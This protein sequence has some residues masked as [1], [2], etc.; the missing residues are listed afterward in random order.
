MRSGGNS[1]GRPGRASAPSAPGRAGFGPD[2]LLDRHASRRGGA[3]APREIGV[4]GRA[5]GSQSPARPQSPLSAPDACER[6]VPRPR[7]RIAGRSRSRARRSEAASEDGLKVPAARLRKFSKWR[8][9]GSRAG[10]RPRAPSAG[11]AGARDP[12]RAC[13]GAARRR[14]GGSATRAGRQGPRPPAG[15]SCGSGAFPRCAEQPEQV[16]LVRG[17]VTG[18]PADG[19]RAFLEIDPSSPSSRRARS[20][21]RP[22]AAPRAA[23]RAA[24]P[25]AE[26]LG[27]VVVRTGVERGDLLA[28]PRPP[29]RGR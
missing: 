20:K 15:S 27:D 12:A 14:R 23:A 4:G 6:Q 25:I 24:R 19:D 5:Q 17:E 7:A 13:G 10:S 18:S 21:G 8:V 28:P 1:D 11:T 26:R 3:V 16:E 29:R 2:Q 22:V 9:A